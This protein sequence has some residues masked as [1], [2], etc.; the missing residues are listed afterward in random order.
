M[1]DVFLGDL[2]GDLSQIRLFHILKL[3]ISEGK[4]G[5]LILTEGNESGEIYVENGDVTHASSGL[6]TGEDALF[7]MMT[8]MVGKFDFTPGLLPEEKSI[9]NST[10]QL[11]AEGQKRIKEWECLK[12]VIP[13][14]DVVFKLS[15]Y[16]SSDDIKL[17]SA[18]WN[19]LTHVDGMRSIREISKALHVDEIGVAKVLHGLFS[20]G[21]LV[22]VETSKPPPEK[23][24]EREFLKRVDKEL[25]KALGPIASVIVDDQIAEMGQ[26]REAFP[27]NKAAELVEAVSS[28]ITDE[29][30]RIRFQRNML[31]ILRDL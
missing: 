26:Q 11:L 30:K 8:W 25:A 21:L 20:A 22:V 16:K 7:T 12:E 1:V 19:I 14:M 27:R 23:A 18:E 3:L 15:G 10:D 2:S 6:D 28:E 17:K 4:T 29:G 31:E 9:E 13:S 5:K 24:V